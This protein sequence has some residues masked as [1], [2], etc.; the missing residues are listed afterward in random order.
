MV[1]K[2]VGKSTL[3]HRLNCSKTHIKSAKNYQKVAKNSPK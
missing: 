3:K 2:M 1:R